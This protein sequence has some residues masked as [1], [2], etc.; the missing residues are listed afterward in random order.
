M[1]FVHK[2]YVTNSHNR[3]TLRRFAQER[4]M[5]QGPF[6]RIMEKIM[7]KFSELDMTYIIQAVRIA[8]LTTLI[9]KL[10]TLIPCLSKLITNPTTVITG[11]KTGENEYE[12]IQPCIT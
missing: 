7:I 3:E 10:E 9:A 8:S 2:S 4:F 11:L 12:V 5:R 6:L 1:Q